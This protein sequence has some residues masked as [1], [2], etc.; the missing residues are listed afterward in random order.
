MRDKLV[1]SRGNKLENQHENEVLIYG[2]HA[3]AAALQ[4]PKRIVN[5]AWST[6]EC[7]A[8]VR[9]ML[10]AGKRRPE[11]LRIVER[12]VL[13]EILPADA[14]HQGMVIAAQR[15]KSCSIEDVCDAAEA[16]DK[17]CVL[18]L[19]QVTDPQNVGAIIRSCAAFG[20]L[21]L[22]MQDKNSPEESGAMVKASAGT[23]E[24]LP[25]CRVTNLN[26]AI[27][28]LKNAGFW[29]V[30]MDGYAETEISSISKGGK[31]AVVMGSEGKG[32]RRLV[33]ESCDQTV[34]LKMNPKVE[35]LNVST[36]AAIALYEVTKA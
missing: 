1:K 22:I 26:R 36:A 16:E 33:K 2:R 17:A 11:L 20:V 29:V 9:N 12:K 19:D 27:E 25:I 4:N 34:K 8:E 21:A 28:R 15:L 35:S 24:L 30:G 13:E 14:V 7:A 6:V 10:A 31:I 23:I 32:M 18:V 5:K 3:V